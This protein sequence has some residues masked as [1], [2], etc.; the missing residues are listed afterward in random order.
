MGRAELAEYLAGELGSLKRLS[1]LGAS[2]FAETFFVSTSRHEELFVKFTAEK[3][4]LI[5]AER[6]GLQQLRLAIPEY[7]PAERHFGRD[8]DWALLVLPFAPTASWTERHSEEFATALSK[9]HRYGG[10]RYGLA[11][12]NF[13]GSSPQQNTEEFG[14][15]RFFWQS[16]LLPQLTLGKQNGWVTSDFEQLL[17][18]NADRIHSALDDLDGEPV[19]I[20]GD[21]WHGNVLPLSH[22]KVWL[23]DPAFS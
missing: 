6:E 17:I 18:T 16:R 2:S 9:L 19:L 13:I 15:G 22:G 11:R 20:H 1:E 23:I 7:V 10:E 21:L 4:E 12:S 14:W 3:P 5:E 8:A